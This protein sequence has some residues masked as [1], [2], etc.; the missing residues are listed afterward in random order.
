MPRVPVREFGAF[1]CADIVVGLQ[2]VGCEGMPESMGGHPLGTIHIAE[3]LPESIEIANKS[4]S[5]FKHL[6]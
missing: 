5:N 1:L 3:I 6:C 2:Q 4:V